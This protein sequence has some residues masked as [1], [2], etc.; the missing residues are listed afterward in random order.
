MKYVFSINIDCS[1]D[2]MESVTVKYPLMEEQ[3]E[4]V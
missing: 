2:A 1:A 3:G 4:K